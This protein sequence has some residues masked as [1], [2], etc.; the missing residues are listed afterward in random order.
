MQLN[1]VELAR[2]QLLHVFV[3]RK[4]IVCRLSQIPSYQTSRT[5]ETS[6]EKRC[7]ELQKDS[8]IWLVDEPWCIASMQTHQTFTSNICLNCLG[9]EKA[10]KHPTM[11]TKAEI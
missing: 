10:R 7:T 2:M 9:G 5:L 6:V 8:F 3:Y 4:L 1:L 11:K